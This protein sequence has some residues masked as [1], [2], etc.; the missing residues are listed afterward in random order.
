MVGMTSDQ[1]TIERQKKIGNAMRGLLETILEWIAGADIFTD[2]I[3]LNQLLS[4]NQ[5]RA[6]STV[7]IFSLIAPFFAC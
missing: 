2:M 1:K 4:T 7:T 6:W 5:H 3:V